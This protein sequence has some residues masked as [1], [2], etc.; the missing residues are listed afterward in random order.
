VGNENIVSKGKEFFVLII[1]QKEDIQ[2]QLY[3]T[4]Q[5][6]ARSQRKGGK[7]ALIPF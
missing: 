3:Q 7:K 5:W 1:G 6:D 4:K 2:K